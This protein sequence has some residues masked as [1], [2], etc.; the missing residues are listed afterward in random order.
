MDLVRGQRVKLG[1]LSASPHFELEVKVT[2]LDRADLLFLGLLLDGSDTVIDGQGVVHE[3][4]RS[5]TCGGVTVQDRGI[6]TQTFAVDLRKLPDPVK[7]VS[8]AL[9]M[10]AAHAPVPVHADKIESCQ[11]EL[12]SEGRVVAR[13]AFRGADFGK[14]SVLQLVEVYRKDVWRLAVVAAGFVGGMPALMSR[15][16]MPA[17][18]TAEAG[19]APGTSDVG[20]AVAAGPAPSGPVRVP[21][22]WAGDR[23]PGLPGGVLR[24]VGMVLSEQADGRTF[25]GTGFLVGPGGHFLTCSHVIEG[26]RTVSIVMEG[27]SAARRAELV[28]DNPDFD[29]ALLWIA[30]RHGSTDWMLLADQDQ[31]PELGAELGLLGYPLG[32][33]LG[34]SVTYSQGIINSVRKKGEL[35]VL[36]VDTGAAP[37]S[38]G[39]PVFR[40]SDGRVV[41][42]LTSGLNLEGRGMLANFAIDIRTV[43]RLGWFSRA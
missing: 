31:A 6:G 34:H 26:A 24:S 10:G 40:R 9:S 5:S 28:Q 13:S 15:Y 4:A 3:R 39:G 41:G 17:Q 42:L 27:T 29:L 32:T 30:D 36:Q 33:D 25:S 43:W 16:R 37:G 22:S 19:P 8:F 38:S 1:D 7:K 14:E 12:R 18:P 21:S 35:N 23:V 11:V 2:G 20:P